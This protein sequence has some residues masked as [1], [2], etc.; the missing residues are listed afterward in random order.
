MD[1]NHQDK[2]GSKQIATETKLWLPPLSLI[3]Q[4]KRD[5]LQKE[6]DE[7]KQSQSKKQEQASQLHDFLIEEYKHASGYSLNIQRDRTQ[8]F[9]LYVVML[10][11][12]FY[13]F[14]LIHT[15]HPDI[16]TN[17]FSAGLLV[18]YSF[19]NV[20]NFAR[21]VTL[22]INY[23]DSISRMDEIRQYYRTKFK[24]HSLDELYKVEREFIS[25][26]RLRPTNRVVCSVFT[27][28]ELVSLVW[29]GISLGIYLERY[30]LPAYWVVP[31][32]MIVAAIK[33]AFVQRDY[34]QNPWWR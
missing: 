30:W 26:T 25:P 33:I 21:F 16:D 11:A 27:G 14:V 32:L 10:G 28:L 4:E 8:T 22:E 31:I 23:R 7:Q 15:G 2:S 5:R 29:A 19:I 3:D 20:V 12:L 17:L 9:N 34:Y 18:F 6:Q 1:E 13:A 24:T